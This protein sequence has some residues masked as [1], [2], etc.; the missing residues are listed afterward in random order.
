MIRFLDVTEQEKCHT[1]LAAAID[2]SWSCSGYFGVS[3][4]ISSEI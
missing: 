2:L 3:P 4:S 1:A